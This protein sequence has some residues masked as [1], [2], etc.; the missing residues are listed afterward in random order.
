LKKE[1]RKTAQYLLPEHKPVHSE[2]NYDIYPSFKLEENRIFE[3]YDSLADILLNARTVIIDGYIGVF[4]D[5][6]RNN[7]A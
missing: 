7:L 1:W 6:F 4:Y 5:N 3:G 2:G